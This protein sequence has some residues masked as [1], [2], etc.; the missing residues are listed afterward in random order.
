M[1]AVPGASVTEA[2]APVSAPVRT[3]TDGP[4]LSSATHSAQQ[5]RKPFFS[6]RYSRR[7]CSGHDG[8]SLGP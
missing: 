2:A 1:G 8:R 3:T 6:S 7:L 5:Q 4:S